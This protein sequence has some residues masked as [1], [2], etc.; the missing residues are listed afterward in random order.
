MTEAITPFETASEYAKTLAGWAL[1]LL[2]GSV[3]ALMQD[4]Y[5]RPKSRWLRCM[6][7]LFPIGWWFLAKS[8]FFGTK[9][10]EVLLSAKFSSQPDMPTLVAE[11]NEDLVQQ[12]DSFMYALYALGLWLLLYLAWWILDDSKTT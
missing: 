9:A 7:L 8:I 12:I 2:G 4:S 1:L 10:Y 3:L 5:L 6:Y 11:I